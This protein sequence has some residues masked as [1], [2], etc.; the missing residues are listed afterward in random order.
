MANRWYR[1]KEIGDGISP[2]DENDPENTGPYRPKGADLA[3][4]QSGNKRHPKDSPLWLVRFY[5]DAATLD[6]IA[7]L[8]TV[9]ELSDIPDQALNNMMGQNRSKEEWNRGFKVGK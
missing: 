2:I 7:N 1:A 8:S 6:E 5:G 3:N 9:N 4:G